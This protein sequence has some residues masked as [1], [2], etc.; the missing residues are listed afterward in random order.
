MPSEIPDAVA[1]VKVLYKNKT[2]ISH[3]GCCRIFD[4][5]IC[6]CGLL[7]VCNPHPELR[8]ISKVGDRR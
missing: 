7:E 6:N 8:K 1:A 4:T 3:W 2:E 5:G